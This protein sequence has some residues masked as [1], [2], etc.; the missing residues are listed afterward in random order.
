[1][2]VEF[3]YG[4][5]EGKAPDLVDGVV[6]VTETGKSLRENGLKEIGTVFEST[7]QLIVSP[8][9]Y[10]NVWKRERLEEIAFALR[11]VLYGATKWKL[12]FNIPVANVV[13]ILREIPAMKSPDIIET[14]NPEWKK[15]TT[16]IDK[17]SY[18]AIVNRIKKGGAQSILANKIERIVPEEDLMP[19]LL[20]PLVN[21]YFELNVSQI[22]FGKGAGFNS[23]NYPRP[24]GSVRTHAWIHE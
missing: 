17:S 21:Q 3:S 5:T 10:E 14:S 6:D 1:M 23:R 11:S 15:I 7:P 19:R 16:V 22:D 2:L 8:L 4:A 24:W 12:E 18:P 13:Q 20:G 9:T